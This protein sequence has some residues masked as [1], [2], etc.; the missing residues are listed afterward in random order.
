MTGVVTLP[1]EVEFIRVSPHG[2]IQFSNGK[3]NHPSGVPGGVDV[4]LHISYNLT[5]LVPDVAGE[6]QILVVVVPK[7]V[8]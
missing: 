6:V 5:H 4:F 7:D 2:H 1:D 3:V 8:G